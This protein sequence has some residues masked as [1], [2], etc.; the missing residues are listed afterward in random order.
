MD[1]KFNEILKILKEDEE[2]AYDDWEDYHAIGTPSC[3]AKPIDVP[4]S[5]HGEYFAKK[6]QDEN[7]YGYYNHKDNKLHVGWCGKGDNLFKL[8]SFIKNRYQ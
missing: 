1:E 2:D 6:L 4:D 3:R 5:K 8:R 7:Y